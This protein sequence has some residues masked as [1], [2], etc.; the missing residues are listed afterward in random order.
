M[1]RSDCLSRSGTDLVSLRTASDQRVGGSSPSERATRNT[2]LEICTVSKSPDLTRRTVTPL[3][4]ID[5]PIRISASL[6]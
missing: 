6:T 2:Y 1:F 4:V 5:S 3:T